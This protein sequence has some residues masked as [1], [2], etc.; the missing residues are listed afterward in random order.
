M[1]G[2]KWEKNQQRYHTLYKVGYLK[3]DYRY[4]VML[5]CL[6][7][8]F[9]IRTERNQINHANSEAVT[10]VADIRKMILTTLLHLEQ[11]EKDFTLRKN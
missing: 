10:T 11:I 3:S 5:K 2:M 6:H 4:K 1:T 9:L 7:E 8:Y